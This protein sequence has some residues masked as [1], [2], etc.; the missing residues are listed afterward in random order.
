[1]GSR[2]DA[3]NYAWDRGT[4]SQLLPFM[5]SQSQAD[6]LNQYAFSVSPQNAKA[7]Q[8]VPRHLFH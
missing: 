5:E 6:L 7:I 4:F 3:Q 8:T 2:P 1:M